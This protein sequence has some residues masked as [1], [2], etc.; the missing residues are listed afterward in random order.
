MWVKLGDAMKHVG[1]GFTP[2][3]WGFM[4]AF[5]EFG[6]GIFV[7]LGLFTR[8]MAAL[9]FITMMVAAIM[10]WVEDGFMDGS[11]AFELSFVFLFFV[12]AGA[13]KFSCDYFFWGKKMQEAGIRN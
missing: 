7:A 13:G 10:H 6:G 2:A 5:G 1:L 4:A 9:P 12:L 8:P 3:F 11:H